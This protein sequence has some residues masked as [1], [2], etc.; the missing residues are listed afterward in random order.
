M[1]TNNNMTTHTASLSYRF[2]YC[3][4]VCC[5][6]FYQPLRWPSM[7]W[8]EVWCSLQQNRCFSYVIMSGWVLQDLLQE[9]LVSTPM[10]PLIPEIINRMQ[11]LCFVLRI[12]KNSENLFNFNHSPDLYQP[13]ANLKL[14]SKLNAIK[15]LH[16]FVIKMVTRQSNHLLVRITGIIE[17]SQSIIVSMISLIFTLIM[18]CRK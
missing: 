15:D 5:C 3:N 4:S 6:C 13:S 10:S 17:H 14:Q 11:L 8:S 2:Y 9:C 1:W 12:Y 18:W 16:F 7:M